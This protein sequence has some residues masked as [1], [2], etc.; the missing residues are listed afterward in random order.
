M[1]WLHCRFNWITK[2]LHFELGDTKMATTEE[3]FA[4]FRKFFFYSGL[5]FF[6]DGESIAYKVNTVSLVPTPSVPSFSLPDVLCGPTDLIW[7]KGTPFEA[8]TGRT[9][10]SSDTLIISDQSDGRNTRGKCLWLRTRTGAGGT[11]T[12]A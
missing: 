4:T 3:R 7:M 8:M 10:P 1:I 2:S 6:G 11:A 12:L 9:A 5:S